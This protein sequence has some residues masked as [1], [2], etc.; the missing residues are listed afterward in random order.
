MPDPIIDAVD[1]LDEAKCGLLGLM[2]LVDAS[3]EDIHPQS[4][5]CLLRLVHA[6]IEAAHAVVAAMRQPA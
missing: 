1:H 4:F 2:L 5:G 6:R 3:R